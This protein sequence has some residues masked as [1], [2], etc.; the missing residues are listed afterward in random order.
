MEAGPYDI[1]LA[2]RF[3]LRA[4]AD[5]ETAQILLSNGKHADCAYHCQ[6]VGEKAGKAV[7][8][9]EGRFARDHV[10]SHH[11]ER[12]KVKGLEKIVLDVKSLEKHWVK[13]RYPEPLDRKIWDP[14]EGYTKKDAEE[15]LKRAGAVFGA[16]RKIMEE[17]YNVRI[18]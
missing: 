11:L 4:K 8:I 6:Q 18:Q 16:I 15:A 9:L 12:L 14:L 13:T 7:L 1:E 3:L 2:R 5:M 10:I 17:N